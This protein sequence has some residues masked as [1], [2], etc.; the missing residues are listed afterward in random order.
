M[1]NKTLIVFDVHNLCYRSWYA[2]P[3]LN[4]KGGSTEVIYGF[5]RTA[6]AL[7]RDLAADMAAFCFESKTS[8][9]KEQFPEY[10]ARRKQMTADGRDKKELIIQ[11]NKLFGILKDQG[12]KNVFRKRGMESDDLMARIAEDSDYTTILVTSDSDLFQCLSSRVRIYSPHHKRM[13][14]PK[15]F[16]EQHTGISPSDW[17]WVKA[18][19]G[20]KTDNVPGIGGVGEKTAIK[21][22]ITEADP[23]SP[24]YKKLI[25]DQSEQIIRRNLELVRLP[26]RA[27]PAVPI[28]REAVP[29]WQKLYRAIGSKGRIP[30]PKY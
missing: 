28:T 29:N 15:W 10:K 17:A 24:S 9:R 1:K 22:V 25:N 20:C 8:L 16:A 11:I 4:Y 27:C 19:A 7:C 30:F 14:G 21:W 23:K 6:E 3:R 2:L 13:L 5:L 12:C 26:H 18:V